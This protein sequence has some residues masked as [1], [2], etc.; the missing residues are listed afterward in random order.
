V[1]NLKLLLPFVC[2]DSE[3]LQQA[4]VNY[5]VTYWTKNN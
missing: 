2:D 5:R 3:S 4:A 1:R